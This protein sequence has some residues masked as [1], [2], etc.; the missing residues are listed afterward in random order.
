MLKGRCNAE[1]LGVD[2]KVI[3]RLI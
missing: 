1:E 2:G 3:L